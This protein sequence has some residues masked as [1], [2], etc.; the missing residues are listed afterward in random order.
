MKI[1][2]VTESDYLE[3][4]PHQKHHLMERLAKRGHEIRVIDYELLW[5]EHKTKEIISERKVFRNVQ[6][7]ANEGNITV[8]RPPILKIPILSYMSL[9]YTHRREIKKQIEEFKPDIIVGWDILNANIAVKLAKKSG[10]PFI[11]YIVDENFRLVPQKY[12]QPLGRFIEIQ[13]MKKADKILT[14]NEQ[15]RKYIIQMGANRKKITIIRA[16]VDLEQYDQNIDGRK[17]RS[18]YGI[19]KNDVV[20]FFMGWLYH[21]S[22]LKEVAKE[23]SKISKT[24]P[25]IKL[26]IVGDGDCYADLQKIRR[27][28]QMNNQ[29]ILTGRQPYEKIPEFISAADICLLP[30]YPTEKTMQNNVPIKM[31]EYMVMR[32]PVI[33]TRLPGIIL[34]FGEDHGVIYVDQSEMVL[35]KAIELIE[36]KMIK[37][38]ATKAREF[39]KKN[40]WDNLVDD[41]E[42]I[43]EELL[44][45]YYSN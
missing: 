42:R 23:L 17:I 18:Q 32:K 36:N 41:F 7:I 13:N 4:G 20:L 37:E 25:H 22:G 15:L 5:R 12:F 2:M 38:H 28:N 3:R 9:I 6:T 45:L 40:S 8:I 11:L 35:Y 19:E 33:T 30:A 43:L 16:G 44:C 1:L 21:F 31:Y 29:M 27:D 14:I 34:E 10:I 24:Y 26:L 39:V